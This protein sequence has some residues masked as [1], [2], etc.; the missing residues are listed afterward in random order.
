MLQLLLDEHISPRLAQQLM[1]KH[2]GL[3]IEPVLH[4]Q[5]GQFLGTADEVLLS[6]AHALGWTLVT[7]DQATITPLLKCWAEQ[8]HDHGG[9]IFIDGRTIASDDF[10]GL[11]RALGTVWRRKRND[12][13]ENVVLY[14]HQS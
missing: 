6:A 5:S 4:W 3:P 12:R 13:W 8:G 10:G 7:Y 14:L 9:V 2:R 11:V 1:P